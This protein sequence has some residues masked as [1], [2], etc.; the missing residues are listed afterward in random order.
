MHSVTIQGKYK[1][2]HCVFTNICIYGWLNFM[3]MI[4]QTA[5]SHLFA[6]KVI[7]NLMKN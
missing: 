1:S 6:W 2:Q 5:Y 3:A 7:F 4:L